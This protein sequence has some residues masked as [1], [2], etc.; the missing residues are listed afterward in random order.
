MKKYNLNQDINDL[1]DLSRTANS[2]D[3]ERLSR[4]RPKPSS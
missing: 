1:E 4:P 2:L 3:H